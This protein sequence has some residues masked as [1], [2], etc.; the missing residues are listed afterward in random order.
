[1]STG[2][3]TG[4]DVAVAVVGGPFLDLTFEGLPALPHPGEELVA[5]ALHATPGGTGMQAVGL[6]RLGVSTALA[7]PVGQDVGGRLLA[8]LFEAEGVRWTGRPAPSTSV[9][10]L[11]PSE[12]GAAMTTVLGEGE[13]QAEDVAGAGAGVVVTSLG[14]RHLV[15]DDAVAYLVTGPM[16]TAAGRQPLDDLPPRT[17]AIVCNRAE[18]LHL[19]GEQDEV[20]AARSLARH[21]PTA[22][23]TLAGDGAVAVEGGRWLRTQAPAVDV[24]DTTGAGDLFVAAYVWADLQGLGIHQRVA[25]ACLYATLSVRASTAFDGALRLEELLDE[26]PRRGLSPP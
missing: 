22:V 10:V 2:T 26:G 21:A 19:T 4:I 23:V 25:W 3:G 24:V 11:L 7:A 12:G 14:R 20:A 5:R 6:A 9:T 1:M 8:E 18:A 16:E 13:P 15:P 17:R